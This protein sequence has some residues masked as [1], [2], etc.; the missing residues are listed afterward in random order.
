MKCNG[1]GKKKGVSLEA[2]VQ[3]MH[4]HDR[5]YEDTAKLGRLVDSEL[6]FAALVFA[7]KKEEKKPL[8]AIQTL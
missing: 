8:R 6:E 4:F 5:G 1:L 7:K 2:L 3:A